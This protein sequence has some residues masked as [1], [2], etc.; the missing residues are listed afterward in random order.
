[1]KSIRQYGSLAV[2]AY[3]FNLVRVHRAERAEG[4]EVATTPLTSAER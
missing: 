2:A 1:M 4:F 3:L